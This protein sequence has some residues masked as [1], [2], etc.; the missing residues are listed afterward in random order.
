MI[1]DRKLTP[2]QER[3]LNDPVARERAFNALK[4]GVLQLLQ[5]V[6]DNAPEIQEAIRQVEKRNSLSA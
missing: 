4:E 2:A 6:R 3:L 5:T 1:T